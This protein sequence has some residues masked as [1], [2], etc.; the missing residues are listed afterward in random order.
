[1]K[2][3]DLVFDIDYDHLE[4]PILKESRKQANKLLVFDYQYGLAS[5]LLLQA[6]RIECQAGK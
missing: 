6:C 2:S 3:A 1:M 5:M 4:K